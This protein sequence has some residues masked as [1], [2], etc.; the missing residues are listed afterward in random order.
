MTSRLTIV[1]RNLRALILAGVN[2]ALLY[3]VNFSTAQ[4]LSVIFVVPG[5]SV[6]IT[7]FTVP[8]ILVSTFLMTRALGTFTIMWTVYSAA[9]IPTFLM[10]PPGPYKVVIGF[11]AGFVFDFVVW[12]TK[13]SNIGLYSGF[14]AYSL[15]LMFMF[16]GALWFLDLPGFDISMITVILLTGVFIIEGLVATFAAIKIS[17]RLQRIAG[18]FHPSEK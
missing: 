15:V 11:V 3:V 12:L 8:F 14:I 6:L 4:L 17:P 18:D 7:G 13:G 9:A 10:G 16:L 2:T 5:L 1:T